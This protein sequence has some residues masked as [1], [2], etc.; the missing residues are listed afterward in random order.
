[1]KVIQLSTSRK[2]MKK[3]V[4]S[5]VLPV[6]FLSFPP[7]VGKISVVE[8]RHKRQ[9]RL[10]KRFHD[11]GPVLFHLVRY[12]GQEIF[13]VR[14]FWH[15][16]FRETISQGGRQFLFAKITARVHRR[17]N[18]KLWMGHDFLHDV[19]PLF[20]QRQRS[21]RFQHTVQSFQHRVVGQ[22][23]LVQ[24]DER[25][26]THGLHQ[27]PVVPTKQGDKISVLL[28]PLTNDAPEAVVVVAVVAV[29][30]GLVDRPKKIRQMFQ[31]HRSTASTPPHCQQIIRLKGQ[32]VLETSDTTTASDTASDTTTATTATTL[33]QHQHCATGSFPKFLQRLLAS[34]D[35]A[36]PPQNVR[37]LRVLVAIQNVQRSLQFFRQQLAGGGFA[38][39]GAS[40]QQH[41]FRHF[42]RHRHQR[43]HSGQG[44][45]QGHTPNPR[46]H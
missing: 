19:S 17:K 18:S 44:I 46:G 6:F 40:D 4:L 20:R 35:R 21:P 27:W 45:G 33:P 42:H 9:H 26:F 30:Q 14:D 12:D 37:R 2:V 10:G 36:Q 28:Q 43:K 8:P 3:A 39:A 5:A 41:R 34:S 22:R 15:P 24:Q 23:D 1:M 31:L 32:N 7:L 11:L 13:L 16:Y 25:T 38:A 29:E